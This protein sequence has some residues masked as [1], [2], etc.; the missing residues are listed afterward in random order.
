MKNNLHANPLLY[1]MILLFTCFMLVILYNKSKAAELPK[2]LHSNLKAT[3]SFKQHIAENSVTV[4]FKCSTTAPMQL[5][6]FTADGLLIK[7]VTIETQKL[8]IIAGLQRGY[9]LYECFNNDERI[10]AGNL[11]VK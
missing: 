3:I 2:S 8:T 7:E 4:K 9:Y 5:F 10:N 1:K 6:I 11:I